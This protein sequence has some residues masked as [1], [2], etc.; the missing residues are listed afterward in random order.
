[1]AQTKQTNIQHLNISTLDVLRR[2]GGWLETGLLNGGGHLR[3]EDSTSDLPPQ[4]P[5]VTTTEE[6]QDS[7]DLL[8]RIGGKPAKHLLSLDVMLEHYEMARSALL[9]LIYS[10]ANSL[11]YVSVT[12]DIT[13]ALTHSTDHSTA[14]PCKFFK[15]F[16]KLV[17]DR[18]IQAFR[19]LERV[20]FKNMNGFLSK[21]GDLMTR[22]EVSK[23]R[24][25]SFCQCDD[26]TSSF[27]PY[28]SGF[29][30]LTTLIF[31]NSGKI[32]V[33][34]ECLL[35]LSRGLEALEVRVEDCETYPSIKA[36]KQHAK[37]LKR[38]WLESWD[39]SDERILLEASGWREHEDD[40]LDWRHVVKLF[41]LEEFCAPLS[42]E[43]VDEIIEGTYVSVSFLVMINNMFEA[44]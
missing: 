40:E 33:V 35:A 10:N 37:T 4:T 16:E 19:N 24:E 20:R 28:C 8:L 22:V 31:D 42:I 38:L 27:L 29:T 44:S 14:T 12:A 30:G 9:Y 13:G 39:Q 23:I 32:N 15:D 25:L 1:M 26:A 2:P 7:Q 41:T 18:E 6:S 43:I 21:I 36:M 11:R 3:Q 17:V 5:S 34:N